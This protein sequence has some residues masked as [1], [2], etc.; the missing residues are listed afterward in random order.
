[1][2]DVQTE[3]KKEAEKAAEPES[4]EQ[5]APAEQPMATD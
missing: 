2:E 3:E 5:A 1:M 4:T